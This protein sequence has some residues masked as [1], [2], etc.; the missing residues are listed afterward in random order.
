MFAR[1]RLLSRMNFRSLNNKFSST[2]AATSGAKRGVNMP[3][4]AILGG[5]SLGVMLWIMPST[6]ACMQGED[7]PSGDD[8]KKPSKG[9]MDDVEKII[10]TTIAPLATKLGYGGIMG[11]F[12]GI[13]LKKVGEVLA[14]GIGVVFVGL[15]FLQYKGLIDIDYG[16][17]KE[18][19][20]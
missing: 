16:T 11:V 5:G 14:I 2:V 17:V 13:A 1:T 15:Q 3:R 18:K 9:P 12:S 19:G 4:L 10:M 8:G 6:A 20:K 7:S